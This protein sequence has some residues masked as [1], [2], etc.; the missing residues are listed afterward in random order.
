[1]VSESIRGDYEET[2]RVNEYLK[3]LA[4]RGE[5][6]LIHPSGR[7][8]THVKIHLIEPTRDMGDTLDFNTESIRLRW[9]HG[10][11]RTKEVLG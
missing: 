8:L 1:M 10:I 5:A 11:R 4:D 6:P 7:Q 9:E 2:V 3:Q